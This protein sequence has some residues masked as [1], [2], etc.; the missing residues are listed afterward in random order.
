MLAH[1]S[2]L[3]CCVI[4]S[5]YTEHHQSSFYQNFA[6]IIWLA[7]LLHFEMKTWIGALGPLIQ[8]SEEICCSFDLDF[9]CN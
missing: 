2:S 7:T 3:F 1:V 5:C 4:F 6:A 8:Q 9:G